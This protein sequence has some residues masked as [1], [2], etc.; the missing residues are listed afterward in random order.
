MAS[1]HG[2]PHQQAGHM[3][4]PTSLAPPSKKTLAKGEPSTHGTMPTWHDV[5]AK[6]ANRHKTDGSAISECVRKWWCVRFKAVSMAPF[7]RHSSTNGT[8]MPS[9]ILMAR[10]SG[11]S[12]STQ[13]R[14]T[15]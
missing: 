7:Q 2:A 3:A 6:S 15:W 10:A 12:P 8:D 9:M 5:R 14:L 4:A 1:G 13:P 11:L